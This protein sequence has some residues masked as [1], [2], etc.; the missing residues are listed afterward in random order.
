VSIRTGSEV[1]WKWGP[2]R[3]EGKVVEI[4]HDSVTRTL[5]GSEITRHGD[6]D[7]PAYLIEQDDGSQVLKLRSEVDRA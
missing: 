3:A 2:N 6:Q 1:S 5:Q 7:N 4:F